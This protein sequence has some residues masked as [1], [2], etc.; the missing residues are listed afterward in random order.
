MSGMLLLYMY[1][2]VVDFE[3]AFDS[4]HKESLDHHKKTYGIPNKLTQMVKALYKDF[5]CS[6]IEGNETM[7]PFSVMIGVKQSCQ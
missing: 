7:A 3:K 2:H 4:G 5:Q 1:I 6:V